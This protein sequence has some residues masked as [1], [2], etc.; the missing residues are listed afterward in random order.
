MQS[1]RYARLTTSAGGAVTKTF[2]VR[3]QLVAVKIDTGDLSTPDF[4]I[5]DEPDGTN[6]L[7]LT[8]LASDGLYY[9]QAQT[10]DPADGTAGDTYVSPV[11]FGHVQI[12][13]T[14]AGNTKTG[15]V[16]LFFK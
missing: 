8:G 12:A 9:L 6:L 3:G 1:I 11:V 7:T 5:T 10:A 16:W 13:V 14:G 15:E 2:G 4:A